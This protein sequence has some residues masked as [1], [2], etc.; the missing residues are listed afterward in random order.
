[1][2]D[3]AVM[4]NRIHLK[5][6]KGF[7]LLWCVF[8][9]LSG[10]VRDEDLGQTDNQTISIPIEIRGLSAT[11]L[12]RS[13]HAVDRILILPFRKINEGIPANDDANFEPDYTIAKQFPFSS[14]TIYTTM[15]NFSV[16]ST[17]K[18]LVIGYNQ[19]DYDVNNPDDM[20]N[21]FSIGSVNL[22]TL[23]TNFHLL[24][25]SAVVVP[26][27]FTAT[28]SSYNGQDNTGEYFKVE[29]I[30]NLKATIT[31]LISK[32]NLEITNIPEY[33]SSVSLVAEKLV[34]G[35]HPT[36]ATAT[37]I[38][39]VEDADNL[40]T[41][42]TQ[43]PDQGK[44]S[45]DHFL[46]PTLD[47]NKTRLYLDIQYGTSTERYLVKV[48]DTDGVSA[49]NSIIFSPNHEVKISG[50]YSTINIGFTIGHSINMDD[51]DW[52]GIH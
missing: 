50:D 37:V 45:F 11:Y 35:V 19:D 44:V 49:E 39:T 10:C 14:T 40:K 15:L 17:Y 16:G 48:P 2:N 3:K 31:R 28:C 9:I 47:A 27:F 8:F 36:S 52:D 46:L 25:K 38:Q 33:I 34:T 26:E 29:Q 5:D 6:I 24:T 41:F 12:T 18:V 51:D 4:R 13:S 30:T 22:P 42:S 7:C 21:R 23:L 20:N 43:T 32:L 1:M